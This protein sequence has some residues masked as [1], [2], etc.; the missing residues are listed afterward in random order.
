MLK[1][2]VASTQNVWRDRT[3]K[4]FAFATRA[5]IYHRTQFVVATAERTLM[6]VSY[7]RTHVRGVKELLSYSEEHVVSFFLCFVFYRAILHP[8][9][10]GFVIITS[11]PFAIVVS[12]EC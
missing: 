3:D 8:Y 6:S 2:T 7:G 4:L 12:F 10:F 11:A 9:G 1:L 5:A